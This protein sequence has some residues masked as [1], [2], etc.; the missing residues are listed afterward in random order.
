MA[1]ES[2]AGS[3]KAAHTLSRGAG[4]SLVPSIF[5]DSPREGRGLERRASEQDAGDGAAH[6]G[7]DDRAILPRLDRHDAA[8]AER[9]PVAVEETDERVPERRAVDGVARATR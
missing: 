6:R 3:R 8:D 5:M 7:L 4:I 2:T 1:L 9:L